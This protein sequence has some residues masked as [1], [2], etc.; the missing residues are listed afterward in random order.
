ML[1]KVK[2]AA[3]ASRRASVFVDW[4]VSG[5][6]VTPSQVSLQAIRAD[7][8]A[9]LAAAP[10][11]F[12]NPAMPRLLVRLDRQTDRDRPCCDN[13]AIIGLGKAQHAAELRCETCGTHRGWLPRQGFQFLT[14]LAQQFGAPTGPITLRDQQIGDHIMADKKFDNSG[15][16]F[17]NEDKSKDTDRDY[18]GSATIAGVEYWMSGWIK[19]AKSGSKFLKFSFKAKDATAVKPKSTFDDEMNDNIGF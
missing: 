4:Q 16:I 5:A 19:E 3:L 6:E 7:M 13:I 11:L 12:G 1:H 18:R 8:S 9:M 10:D 14:N 17:K 2:P 15:V